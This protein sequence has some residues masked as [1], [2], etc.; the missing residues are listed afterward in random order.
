MLVA[1]VTPLWTSTFSTG[2]SSTWSSNWLKV[3]IMSQGVETV[4]IALGVGAGFAMVYVPLSMLVRTW[5]NR[6]VSGPGE[7]GPREGSLEQKKATEL[8][9]PLQIVAHDMCRDVSAHSAAVD[10]IN[11]ELTTD[12]EPTLEMLRTAVQRIVHANETLKDQLE[13]AKTTIHK[14]AEIIN[15]QTAQ[16]LSDALTGVPNRRVFDHEVT[17]RLA[18]WNRKRRPFSLILCDLDEFKKL[19][20]TYGHVVGDDVLRSVASRFA[21]SVREMDLMARYGGEEFGLVLP[22]TTGENALIVAE[23]VRRAISDTPFLVQN[24][25]LQVTTSVGL[26]EALEGD[27]EQSLIRRADQAL[28]ASKSAGRNCGHIH[29]RGQCKLIQCDLNQPLKQETAAPTINTSPKPNAAPP[30]GTRFGTDLPAGTFS[31][32]ELAPRHPPQGRTS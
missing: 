10:T 3:V 13:E 4:I 20:D 25:N 17:R 23:R 1:C 26:T 8:V 5:L 16:A 12:V 19:N 2:Q 7:K 18:E 15:V 28:Y 9:G 22:D 6:G 30:L 31:L 32:C 14:Q 11:T 21:A 29:H 24:K 27:D